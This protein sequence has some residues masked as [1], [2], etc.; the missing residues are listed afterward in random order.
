MKIA[1]SGAGGFIGTHLVSMFKEKGWEVSTLHTADFDLD[2]TAFGKKLLGAD[3]VIHLAGASISKRWSENY[4]KVLYASRV[5]T[6]KK[7]VT[8]MAKMEQK[9][10]LFICTSAVGIY[11]ESGKYDE[12]HALYAN[13]FLGQL[14][15]A[16]ESAALESKELGIRTIIF[17]YG[18]VLG[19]GGGI[20]K[21]MLLPFK[22]G[23]GGTIGDGKQSF[24]WVHINDLM[25]AYLFVIEHPEMK[26]VYNLMAPN[27]TTNYGLT[28]ALGSALHRPTLFAIPKFLLQLRF[29]SEAAEAISSGQYVTSKRLPEAGFEFEFKTIEAALNNLY[30]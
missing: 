16:W 2:E 21:E 24:S 20:L 27:P 6:A 14:V 15:K 22:L 1:I 25:R 10:Q 28:K 9:P 19:H 30:G 17:R 7:I 12:E 5:D 29:G 18:I 11:A 26:G 4:K 3:V 13:D 8:A 23:L